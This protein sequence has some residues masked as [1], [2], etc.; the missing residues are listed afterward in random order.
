MAMARRMVSGS[1][2]LDIT[3]GG[4]GAKIEQ[5]SH[6][7]SKRGRRKELHNRTPNS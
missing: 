5:E 3:Q 1:Q 7:T 4:V 2:P 6:T